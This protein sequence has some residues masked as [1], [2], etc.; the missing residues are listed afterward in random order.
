MDPF[1]PF[2][3]YRLFIGDQPLLFYL[4]IVFRTVF[5]F[6]YAILLIR[7]MG[8][9]GSR[10]LS[11]FE[12]VVIIALGSATGDSLFY[13]Q[14]PLLYAV[15]V[16]TL[17][18]GCSRLI[19]YL[20]LRYQPV[21]TFIDGYPILMIEQGKVDTEGLKLARVRQEELFGMLR[22]EGLTGTSKIRYA[23]LERSGQLSVICTKEGSEYEGTSILPS[24]LANDVDS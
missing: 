23:F 16:I 7:Y 1:E 10:N 15:L 3:W 18:V 20:Q 4:E 14:V 6:I 19:Q 11:T 22:C 13:P 12:N 5:I 8:K 9:R 2:N 21:N 24:Q 17:I